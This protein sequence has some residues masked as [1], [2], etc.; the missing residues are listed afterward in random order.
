MAVESGFELLDDCSDEYERL[1]GSIIP[2][3]NFNQEIPTAEKK[4]N[5]HERIYSRGL[6]NIKIC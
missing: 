3:W 1:L 6:L 5:F 4:I 2:F